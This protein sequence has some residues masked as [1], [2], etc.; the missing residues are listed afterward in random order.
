M[1]IS[2]GLVEEV[3]NQRNLVSHLGSAQDGKQRTLR[4]F[5]NGCEGI[6]FLLHEKPSHFVGQIDADDRRMR[7]VRGAKGV[8]GIDV[9]KLRERGA[10]GGH[11]FRI[12]FRLGA[13]LVLD[14][15]LP[16]RCGSEDF[17]ARR[18]LPV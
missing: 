7:A 11:L 6:E 8:V 17:R 18:L 1:M 12:G 14:L 10:E 2:F 15:C 4:I 5:K 9:A 16:L 13:V 3:S